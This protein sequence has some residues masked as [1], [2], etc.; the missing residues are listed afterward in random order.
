MSRMTFACAALFLAAGPVLAA[1]AAIDAAVK[2][3][4]GVAADAGKL[5]AYC[6]MNKLMNDVGDDDAK[7]QAAEPQMDAFMKDL[8]PD[9]ETALAAGEKLDEKSP[10]LETYDKAIT[11]LDEKCPK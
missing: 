1:D 10:D 3:L 7:A 8:G 2:T 4:D 9:V 5:K 11:A 6:D